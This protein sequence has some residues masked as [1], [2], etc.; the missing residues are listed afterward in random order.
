MGAGS[1]ICISRSF[2]FQKLK[3]PAML[4]FALVPDEEK[5]LV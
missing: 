1:R 3:F 4:G 2:V 5:Y